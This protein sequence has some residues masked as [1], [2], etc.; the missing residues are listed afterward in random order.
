MS[1][2]ILFTN[3]RLTAESVPR[4]YR[5]KDAVKKS[6]SHLKS[7]PEPFFS[8]FES[9]TRAML[10]LTVLGYIMVAIIAANGDVSY[11]TRL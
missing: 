3:T 8:R 4:I 1:F 5:D 6:F 9:S 11:K 2:T 10:F 7:H